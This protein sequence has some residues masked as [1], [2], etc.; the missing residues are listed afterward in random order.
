M[1]EVTAYQVDAYQGD[2]FQIEEQE[3]PEPPVLEPINPMGLGLGLTDLE[4]E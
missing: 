2:S 3:P 4:L 1:S